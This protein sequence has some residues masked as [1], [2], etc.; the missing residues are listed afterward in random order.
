MNPRLLELLGRLAD[1]TADERAEM[2]EL[3]ATEVTR[4]SAEARTQESVDALVA[5]ADARDALDAREVEVEAAQAALDEAAEA[6]LARLAPAPEVEPEGASAEDDAAVVAEAERVAAEAAAAEGAEGA[7]AEGAPAAE[8]VAAAATPPARPPLARVRANRST[9]SAAPAPAEGAR[10]AGTSLVASVDVPG[11]AAGS[12][13]PTLH[14]LAVAFEKRRGQIGKARGGS[15]D[16]DQVIIAS[17]SYDYPADRVLSL[18]DLNLNMERINAV[19]SPEA[20]VAAGGL[21]A[22]I[23]NIYEIDVV[24]S[25]ARPVR[26]SLPGFN[27]TRGGVS[28]RPSPVFQDLDAASGLW[29]MANDV[30]PSAPTTKAILEVLCQAFE[31]FTVDAVT[32]RL[33]FHNITSK[34]DPEGTAANIQAAMVANARLAENSLLEKMFTLGKIMTKAAAVSYARDVL[35]VLDQL[36]A[37]YSWRH[38]CDDTQTFHVWLPRYVK[39]A[40]RVDMARGANYNGDW[41]LALADAQIDQ[42]FSARNINVTWHLDGRIAA[43]GDLDPGGGTLTIPIQGYANVASLAAV[44]GFP[45]SIEV[46]F[47]MEGDYLFLDGG[48]LDLGIVRDSTLNGVNEYQTFTEQFEG[49]ASRGLESVRL[50]LSVEPTGAA[51]ALKDTSSLTD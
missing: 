30:S 47:A 17:A 23:E 49:I 14:D 46:L 50:N 18:D 43:S 6:A 31:D 11:V 32:M 10:T 26:D 21:C 25:T 3:I 7:P 4:V 28:L 41:N 45:A 33:L 1:L 29:T 34:Y 13:F 5:L 9:G 38:R 15:A 12:A 42:W 37:Y 20:I 40:I 35:T 24:G 39:D 51:A 36:R 8:P 27:A 22:P 44:P 16:G 48:E 2:R 19:V